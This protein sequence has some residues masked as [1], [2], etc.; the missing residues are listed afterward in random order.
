[1]QYNAIVT[2]LVFHQFKA[3]IIVILIQ[4]GTLLLTP[5][6][7]III[8]KIR[9]ML[10]K[11]ETTDCKSYSSIKSAGFALLYIEQLQIVMFCMKN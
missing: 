10:V 6:V 9:V 8:I 3:N 11:L 5:I 7:I 2:S 1:M 4:G